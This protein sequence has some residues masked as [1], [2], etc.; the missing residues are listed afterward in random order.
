MD[1]VVASAGATA[2]NGKVVVC[3]K[4]SGQ[5]CFECI[6]VLLCWKLNNQKG[7][8]GSS[9][10]GIESL[11]LLWMQPCPLYER[12]VYSASWRKDEKRFLAKG[13]NMR[14]KG[15]MFVSYDALL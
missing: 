4:Q 12:N 7:V 10:G 6:G 15:E 13:R 14:V 3:S 9:Q 1:I 11:C 2:G 8:S 5:W